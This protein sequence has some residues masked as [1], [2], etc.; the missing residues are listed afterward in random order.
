MGYFASLVIGMELSI[1]TVGGPMAVSA[2]FPVLGYG[3]GMGP[4]GVGVLHTSGKTIFI[5]PL[6]AWT[7]P[8]QFTNT[9]DIVHSLSF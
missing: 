7:T 5:P 6:P 3:R 9:V 8:R 2:D 1:F 4:P